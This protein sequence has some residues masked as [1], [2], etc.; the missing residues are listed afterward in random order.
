MPS[1]VWL[2]HDKQKKLHSFL[3]H[4]FSQVGEIWLNKFFLRNFIFPGHSSDLMLVIGEWHIFCYLASEHHSAQFK[5]S[6]QGVVEV[7]TDI[8]IIHSLLLQWNQDTSV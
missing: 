4:L 7:E 8:F 3:E 1:S 2:S 6:S 5:P